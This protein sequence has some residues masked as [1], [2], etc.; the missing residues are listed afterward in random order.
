M[1]NP[2]TPSTVPA[3]DDASTDAVTD[4]D[5]SALS[6]GA[7]E[8]VLRSMPEDVRN[9]FSAVQRHA[10]GEALA[11]ARTGRF[12]V[13]LRFSLLGLFVNFIVGKENRSAA[14]RKVERER[15]PFFTLGNLM[16][17]V[18]VWPIGILLGWATYV[19][20]VNGGF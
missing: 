2:A 7:A 11:T 6:A 16:F 1:S 18:F 4:A 13:N 20:L 12:F 8:R 10:L 17:M 19:L 5:L 3:T 9:S 15:H 14:R